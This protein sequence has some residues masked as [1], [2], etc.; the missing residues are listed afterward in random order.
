[1]TLVVCCQGHAC[2]V[3]ASLELKVNLM[4]TMETGFGRYRVV[5]SA[6]LMAMTSA[7]GQVS[8]TSNIMYFNESVINY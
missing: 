7:C 8:D 2:T 6:Y 1:M 5:R 3:M 4:K